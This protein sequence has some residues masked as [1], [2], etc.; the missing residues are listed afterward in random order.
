MADAMARGRNG[1]GFSM[2]WKHD[3]QLRDLAAD[4]TIEITCRQCSFS[5]NRQVAELTGLDRS[6]RLDEVEARL[7]CRRRGCRG[8]V[9]IALVDAEKT[10]GFVGGMP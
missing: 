10:E 3:L 1:R 4:L 5:Y 9:R 2:G 6:L 8:G 7:P